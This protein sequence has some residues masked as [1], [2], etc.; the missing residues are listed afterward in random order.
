MIG[1]SGRLGTRATWRT[2]CDRRSSPWPR[3]ARPGRRRSRARSRDA[4]RPRRADG[5][6]RRRSRARVARGAAGMS[7]QRLRAAGVP[8]TTRPG[9][10][11]A[12]PRRRMPVLPRTSSSRGG[13]FH[14]VHGPGG[15]AVGTANACRV[16]DRWSATSRSTFARGVSRGAAVR[17]APRAAVIGATGGRGRDRA[18]VRRRRVDRERACRGR[19]AVGPPWR[20]S[21]RRDRRARAILADTNSDG[22]AEVIVGDGR[23]LVAYDP[24]TG[25][26]APIGARACRSRTATRSARASARS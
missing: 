14:Q 22:R 23:Q 8:A 20:R 1:A 15:D 13:G 4:R 5:L 12:S 19:A 11:R 6:H 21:P 25:R 16:R 24:W 26:R 7:R 9:G 3:R 10:D 18:A 2:R 17:R